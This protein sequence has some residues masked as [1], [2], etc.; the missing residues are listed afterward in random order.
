MEFRRVPALKGSAMPQMV[1][2]LVGCTQSSCRMA[3]TDV[4]VFFLTL[5]PTGR[6]VRRPG[7]CHMTQFTSPRPLNLR[8]QKPRNPLV[9][10]ALMRQAGKHGHQQHEVRLRQAAQRELRQEILRVGRPDA[11]P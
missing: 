4:S 9:A 11:S 7:D 3:K 5:P 10:P 8:L 6:A 2:F 1:W